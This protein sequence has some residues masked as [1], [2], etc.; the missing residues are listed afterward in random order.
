L[1]AMMGLFDLVGTTL[2][3]WLSDRFNGRWLLFG[4]YGL[5]GLSLLFL[6]AALVGPAAGLLVFA[7]FYG[8]DWIAAAHQL[9]AACATYGAA[10]LR[11]TRGTY[12]LAFRSAGALC[13]IAAGGR[14]AGRAGAARGGGG[15]GGVSG[16]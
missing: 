15:R 8:L 13:L 3:G 11:T 1:L 4:Y 9:G 10:W 2:S 14:V 16:K 6:P 7:V 5:R 12:S